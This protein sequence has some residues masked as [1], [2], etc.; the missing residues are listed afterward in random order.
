MRIL[1]AGLVTLLTSLALAKS[2][3]RSA[4]L[5]RSVTRLLFVTTQLCALVWVFTSYGI[6]IYSTVRLQQVQTLAELS[7]PAIRTILG[8][9]VLKV[10]E[11]I[12]EH[13]DSKIF[14]ESKKESP[15]KDGG[16]EVHYYDES[17]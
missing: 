6:A 13:N 8:V 17:V 15:P 16:E 2:G 4:G 11:N 12:F 3:R 1:F 5:L 14:G 9:S 7:E 10:V